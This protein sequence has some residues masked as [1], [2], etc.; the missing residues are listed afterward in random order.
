MYGKI[1]YTAMYVWH[2]ISLS[3]LEDST[4]YPTSLLIHASSSWPNPVPA[5]LR[6][7]K[8]EMPAS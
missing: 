7:C 3:V 5:V 4:S 2:A 6:E 1:S 8:Y